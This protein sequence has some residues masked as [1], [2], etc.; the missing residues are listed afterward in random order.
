M[1]HSPMMTT[2]GYWGDG[3]VLADLSWLSPA[4]VCAFGGIHADLLALVD[5]GRNLDD[6]AGFE[7]GG[8]GDGRGCGRLDA[9][10]G[11]DNRH[12][13]DERQFDTYGLAVVEADG[14][15]EVGKEIIDGIAEGFTLEHGLLEA[16]VHE[17]VVVAIVVE[18]LHLNFVDDDAIDGIWRAEALDEHGAGADVAQLGLNEGAQVAGRAV[19]YG[20]DEVQI[21]LELDNHA[22]AHLRC[23]NRH[24]KPLICAEFQLC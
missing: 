5:E 16:L 1:P 17:V 18:K 2:I 19:L 7:L 8:L 6:E 11:L 10:L 9:G 12:L 3:S 24:K 22:R 21:V 4:H 23:G 13:D 20:E 15:G 14:D